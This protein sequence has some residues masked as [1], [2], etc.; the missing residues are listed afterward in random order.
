MLVFLGVAIGCAVCRLTQRLYLLVYHHL[1][2]AVV[3]VNLGIIGVVNRS[4]ID[5]NKKKSITAAQHAEESFFEG[6]YP[7]IKHR[8]GTPFLAITL[9]KLLMH[10]IRDCLP[11][12][13]GRIKEMQVRRQPLV[14]FRQFLSSC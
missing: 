11:E 14:L 7:T 10:H 1:S 8:C 4:Q 13:R 9:N 3:K 12:L 5:I 6:S 2:V